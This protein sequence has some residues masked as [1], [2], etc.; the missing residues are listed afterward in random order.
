MVFTMNQIAQPGSLVSNRK[1]K[2]VA[3]VGIKREESINPLRRIMNKRRE[4]S[5][6]KKPEHLR[7]EKQFDK[8]VH[9]FDLQSQASMSNPCSP[10]SD[11]SAQLSPM[12]LPQN[13]DHS[14]LSVDRE[15]LPRSVSF[16]KPK[17]ASSGRGEVVDTIVEQ[18]NSTAG[19]PYM[20]S[21]QG[22]PSLQ[23]KSS[24]QEKT[25]LQGKPSLQEKTNLQ[26]KPS[27]QE[28]NSLHGK[29]SMQEKTCLH[30]K[31]S[32]QEKTIIYCEPSMQEKTN[33]H[34]KPRLQEKTSLQDKPI[35]KE[36]QRREQRQERK[37]K[38]RPKER[39]R[40]YHRSYSS[41]S[42]S[43]FSYKDGYG[44]FTEE[45]R[46]DIDDPEATSGTDYGSN[47]GSRTD[48]DS[49]TDG[50]DTKRYKNGRGS[51]RIDKMRARRTNRKL[52]RR[53]NGRQSQIRSWRSSYDS[54]DDISE[55]DSFESSPRQQGA[56]SIKPRS[57]GSKSSTQRRPDYTKRFLDSREPKETI[58]S[59][60]N[61]RREQA[62]S[63]DDDSGFWD[64]SRRSTGRTT[65]A[66]SE[67]AASGGDWW[68]FLLAAADQFAP[69]L[70]PKCSLRYVADHQESQKD[71]P[72]VQIA[73]PRQQ[74]H[75]SS[76]PRSEMQST[77]MY[78]APNTV[79]TSLVIRACET[80]V[81]ENLTSTKPS[82]RLLPD[83]GALIP[84]AESVENNTAEERDDTF[85]KMSSPTLEKKIAS[86]VVTLSP[87][88]KKTNYTT[89]PG[90]KTKTR[91]PKTKVMTAMRSPLLNQDKAF[92]RKKTKIKLKE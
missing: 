68:T 4:S 24:L 33:L 37:D 81:A 8:Y 44:S 58:G 32:L 72:K 18:E 14:V 85:T 76:T 40:R 82:P 80:H 62:F 50:G 9:S 67:A 43:S 36:K 84:L 28:K 25:N 60:D 90:K 65:S 42:I 61:Q 35:N 66:S 10:R 53:T 69:I 52:F 12:H 13:K 20:T 73:S 26:G 51:R 30:D 78:S 2:T 54:H 92:W 71:P 49:T 88:Q 63:S 59:E 23:E 79:P 1:A 86:N 16:L 83:V 70:Q 64:G 48:H 5:E 7:L 29:P 31:P 15:A 91:L 56:I 89:K 27:L 34:D 77:K 22:K 55:Y 38:A 3:N 21:F 87:T 41:S 46:T 6:K 75:T 74:K 19:E 57:A 39:H 45:V 17:I 11:V 47:E